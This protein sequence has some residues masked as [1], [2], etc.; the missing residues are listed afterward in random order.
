MGGRSPTGVRGGKSGNASHGRG[1][2][3]GLQLTPGQ[4]EPLL[5]LMVRQISS[6]AYFCLQWQVNKTT[7]KLQA[8]PVSQE[9]SIAGLP[10]TY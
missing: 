3:L 2:S 7:G 5:R 6:S 1:E 4:T 9:M 8:S 10:K